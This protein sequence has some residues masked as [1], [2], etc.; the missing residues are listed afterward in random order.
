MVIAE[1]GRIGIGVSDPSARFV[2]SSTGIGEHPV[3]IFGTSATFGNNVVELRASRNTTNGSYNFLQAE[4]TSVSSRAKI[5]DSGDLQ[6]V[7]GTYG[8]ISDQNLK[9]NIVDASSQW[10]DIKSLKVRKFNFKESTGMPLS[11]IHI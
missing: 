3:Q 11:L 2:V 9:E 5:L 4:V 8:S 10:A 1:D 7:N 6:N